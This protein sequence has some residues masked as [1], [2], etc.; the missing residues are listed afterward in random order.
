MLDICYHS[1]RAFVRDCRAAGYNAREMI[2]R[3]EFIPEMAPADPWHAAPHMV[4]VC[5]PYA[6]SEQY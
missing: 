5:R 4:L 1:L 2:K 3:R 6:A